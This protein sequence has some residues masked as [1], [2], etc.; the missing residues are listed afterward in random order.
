MN[1]PKSSTDFGAIQDG[2][3]ISTSGRLCIIDSAITVIC[4]RGI[5]NRLC[6]YI[7]IYSQPLYYGVDNNEQITDPHTRV[8]HY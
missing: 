5:I 6:I 3:K 7:Y 4:T 2:I 8:L 1:G